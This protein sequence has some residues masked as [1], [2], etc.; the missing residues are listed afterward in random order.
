MKINTDAP[1]QVVWTSDG[2]AVQ[3]ADADQRVDVDTPEVRVPVALAAGSATVHAV[4]DLYYCAEDA[5]TLCYIEQAAL[6]LP[7]TVV[8]DA[9]GTT[10]TLAYTIPPRD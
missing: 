5:E 6:A 10:L 2:A 7:V 4:L 8:A 9:T 1:S 3:I